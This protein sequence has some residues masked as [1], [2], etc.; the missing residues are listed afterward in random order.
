[1]G[2][3]RT[4]GHFIV[5][6]LVAALLLVALADGGVLAGTTSTTSGVATA[7]ASS[8]VNSFS[9][10]T[11]TTINWSVNQTR[12]MRIKCYYT[13]TPASGK[14]WFTAVSQINATGTGAY[15][16]TLPVSTGSA[17]TIYPASE[18]AS[19]NRYRWSNPVVTVWDDP[20][21]FIDFSID[22]QRIGNTATMTLA[23]ASG[24][25]L[26]WF[27]TNPNETGSPPISMGRSNSEST[28]P[29]HGGRLV[30]SAVID[31]EMPSWRWHAEW[32]D[33]QPFCNGTTVEP[34]APATLETVLLNNESAV[35]EVDEGGDDVEV[36]ARFDIQSPWA[37]LQAADYAGVDPHNVTFTSSY[38]F[39]RRLKFLQ[40]R[41][42]I[43]GDLSWTTRDLQDTDEGSVLADEDDRDRPC[44]MLHLYAPEE[45][46]VEIGDDIE[47]EM[48]YDERGTGDGV[49][50]ALWYDQR[51]P[52]DDA[53]PPD[54][55][56]LDTTISAPASDTYTI[57]SEFDDS[58]DN[59][60][61]FRCQDYQGYWY[62]IVRN[63]GFA[64][65]PI[66]DDDDSS[67]GC[68]SSASFGLNP[69]SWAPGILRAGVCLVGV[70]WLPTDDGV[71]GLKADAEA[72]TERAP[73][74]YVLEVGGSLTGTFDD[75]SASIV[76]H[77]NDCLM[78]LPGGLVDGMVAEACPADF[79][80]PTLSTFRQMI[81]VGAWFTF[82]LA[83]WAMTRRLIANG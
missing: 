64:S 32:V 56:S 3:V 30:S 6:M 81:G 60:M 55:Q 33:I 41:C 26:Q 44:R 29:V 53:D 63:G 36:Q 5:S 23:S 68:I 18:W 38:G 66:G 76:A 21:N 20:T 34:V 39:P 25:V 83:L 7:G 14:T 79:D 70:L 4:L 43:V 54:W 74:S 82:G 17:E 80:S 71:A 13:D 37:V 28:T 77:R 73:L 49:V 69:S 59:F 27:R 75:A 42:R 31:T 78:V 35:L 2:T 19:G 62:K 10:E 58:I 61:Q 50:I 52:F 8:C 1:M 9:G 72:V 47:Y 48:R 45:D 22:I 16:F 15:H 24:T 67:A 40:V 51:R 57:E 46:R 12:T 65:A 11:G